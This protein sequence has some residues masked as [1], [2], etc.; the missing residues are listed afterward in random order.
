ML[1]ARILPRSSPCLSGSQAPQSLV[2]SLSLLAAVYIWTKNDGMEASRGVEVW[3]SKAPLPGPLP[4][5]MRA[6]SWPHHWDAMQAFSEPRIHVST[7]ALVPRSTTRKYRLFDN[8]GSSGENGLIHE[9]I[10]KNIVPGTTSEENDRLSEAILRALNRKG[11]ATRRN[12]FLS[13]LPTQFETAGIHS[14]GY[15]WLR[16]S[17]RNGQV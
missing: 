2:S 4:T 11:K 6:S 7:N 1:A 16:T 10:T 9:T 14:T 3:I 15:E 5:F 8:D 12:L 13:M 17:C